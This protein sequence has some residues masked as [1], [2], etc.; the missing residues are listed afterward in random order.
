M[1]YVHQ[2]FSLI[3]FVHKVPV[4]KVAMIS[5][6]EAKHELSIFLAKVD[7]IAITGE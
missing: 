3:C 4:Y 7:L 1:I 2:S 5:H 6:L